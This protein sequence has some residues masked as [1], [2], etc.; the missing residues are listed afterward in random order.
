M[1]T[2]ASKSYLLVGLVTSI[3]SFLRIYGFFIIDICREDSK[4][5]T[6]AFESGPELLP[7]SNPN[8]PI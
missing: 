5:T 7:F 8:G 6:I 4:S 3:N 2:D 1:Q